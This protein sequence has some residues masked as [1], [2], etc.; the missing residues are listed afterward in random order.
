MWRD[1]REGAARR[2]KHGGRDR[3]ALDARG[4]IPPFPGAPWPRELFAA[5]GREAGASR[6]TDDHAGANRRPVVLP[7]SVTANRNDCDHVC[8]AGGKF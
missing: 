8:V 5:S 4:R 1:Y 2:E 6:E 3:P 7:C